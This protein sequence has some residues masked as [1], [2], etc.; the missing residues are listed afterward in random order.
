[1]M[2]VL[3]QLDMMYISCVFSVIRVHHDMLL[4][5]QSCCCRVDHH[6]SAIMCKSGVHAIS[7]VA[8]L[9]C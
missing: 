8:F 9:V 6:V 5:V 4:S 1:M 3:C 2:L 7:V